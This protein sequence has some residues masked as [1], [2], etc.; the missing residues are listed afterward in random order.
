MKYLLILSTVLIFGLSVM[1]TAQEKPEDEKIKVETQ[2]FEV[3]GMTC[4]SCVNSVETKLGKIDGVENYKVDLDKGE[5][6]VEYNPAKVNAK[7][8]EKEFEGTPYK[9]TEKATNKNKQEE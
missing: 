2:T 6:V 8:I 3:E 5:A 1:V 9:V 4:Q 7:K